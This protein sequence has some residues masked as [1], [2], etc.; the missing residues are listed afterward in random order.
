LKFEISTAS[1]ECSQA[2]KNLPLEQKKYWDDLSAI[3]KRGYMEQKAAYDGPWRIATNK[4]KKTKKDEGAPKR[5]PSAFFLFANV[6]RPLI[7]EDNPNMPPIAVI[8]ECSTMWKQL[9]ELEKRPYLEE[10]QRLR[11]QYHVDVEQWKR[12][13][14]ERKKNNKGV[15]RQAAGMLSS[16]KNDGLDEEQEERMMTDHHLGL[17]DLPIESSGIVLFSAMR[18]TAAAASSSSS[19]P[20]PGGGDDTARSSSTSSNSHTSRDPTAPKRS[21]PAFFLFVNHCRPALRNEYP[22]LKQTELIKL[23]GQKWSAMND[24][25][26]SPF[27]AEEELLRQQYHTNMLH[28]RKQAIP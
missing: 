13:V 22:D 27:R 26:K 24:V 3:E 14:K 28:Y 21:P 19:V 11:A 15:R 12:D 4:V 5:S 18:A 7:K 1:K 9:P 8:K 16:L 10:E 6:T 20:P 2:W 23:L 25:D 17:P